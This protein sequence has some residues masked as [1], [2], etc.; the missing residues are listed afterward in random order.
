MSAM[1]PDIGLLIKLGS[2]VVHAQEMLEQKEVK[3]LF[4]S[5][6]HL[7]PSQFDRAAIEV[8]L[9]DSRVVEW[10]E[11]MTKQAFLPVKRR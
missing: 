9:G 1:K 8:L 7:A 10:I 6:S 11:E 2:I 4:A 5:I 3:H